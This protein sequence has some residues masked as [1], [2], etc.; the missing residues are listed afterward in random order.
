MSDHILKLLRFFERDQAELRQAGTAEVSDTA[1]KLLAQQEREEF[2]DVDL[3]ISAGRKF[4]LTGHHSIDAAV[5]S[6]LTHQPTC[7]RFD[8]ASSFLSGYWGSNWPIQ[9]T[10]AAQI[11]EKLPLCEA[12][13]NALPSMLVA[14]SQVSRTAASDATKT[15]V[16]EVL[17]SYRSRAAELKL[18]RGT[19]QLID[20]AVAQ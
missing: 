6:W 16:R 5:E 17:V 19:I 4:R 11:A 14:L 2:T 9:E 13:S 8:V 20:E 3:L 1:M 15:R 7:K 10:L 12:D 18:Q